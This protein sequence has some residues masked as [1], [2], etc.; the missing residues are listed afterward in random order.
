MS[1]R[2]SHLLIKHS[3]SRR[4]SSWKDPNGNEIRERSKEQAIEKLQQLREKIG[5]L[6]H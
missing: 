4:P 6:R 5:Q 3:G 2:A 1:V